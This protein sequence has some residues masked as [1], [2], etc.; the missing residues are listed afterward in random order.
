MLKTV[1]AGAAVFALAA[2]LVGIMC[3]LRY[4]GSEGACG[5]TADHRELGAAIPIGECH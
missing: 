3:V 1:L 4:Y 2:G 5:M